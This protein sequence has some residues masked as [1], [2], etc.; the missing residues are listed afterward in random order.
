MKTTTQLTKRLQRATLGL[1][2]CCR[3][4]HAFA[5]VLLFGAKIVF[6]DSSLDRLIHLDIPANNRLE[7]SLIE[8]GTQAGMAVMMNTDTVAHHLVHEVH[9]TLSA[10][11]ALLL[12]LRDT[13]LTFTQEGDRIRVIPREP[14]VRSGLR[15]GG[16][17]GTHAAPLTGSS[18]N[19]DDESGE[20]SRRGVE[21]QEVVVTAE[22]REEPLNKVPISITALSQSSMDD[23]HIQKLG[24]L[25]NIVP[26]LYVSSP[27]AFGQ[28]G[29]TVAIRGVLTNNNAPTTQFYIDETPIAIRLM[30]GAAPSG[31]PQPLIFDLDRVEVLRGPQGTLFGASAMGGAI[32]FITPQP[33]LREASG[34]AKADVGYTEHGEASYEMGAAY[35]SP[36]VSG[37]AGFRVSAWYQSIGGFI[38]QED[39]FTGQIVKRNINSPGAYVVRPAFTWAPADGLTIT[40][41]LFLQHKDSQNPDAYWANGLPTVESN[42]HVWGGTGQ[43]MT[44]DLSVTALAIKYDFG[45]VSLQSDTSFLHRKLRAFDDFT[46]IAAYVYGFTDYLNPGLQGFSSTE[47]D[48]SSTNA[49]QQEFRLSSK[50]SSARINWVVGAFYR[51]AT[52]GLSQLIPPDLSPITQLTSGLTYQQYNNLY[53][54]GARDFVY[55]GQVLNAY[56]NFHTTDISEALFGDIGLNLTQRLKVDLGVRVEHT[57]VEHQDQIVAGPFDGL[58]FG[59]AI[60][61]D[62]SATPVTPRLSVTYQYTDN[63]MMYASAA[64]GF[65]P[66][67]GNPLT[68]IGDSLCDVSLHA[69]GLGGVPSGFSPDSLWSYEIGSK[70]FLFDKRLSIDSSVYLIKWTDIQTLVQLPSCGTDFTANRGEALSKGFDLQL[71]ALITEGLKLGVNVGYTNAYYPHT[72]YGAPD[73]TTGIAPLLNAGG[74]KIVPIVPWTVSGTGEYSVDTSSLWKDSRTYLRADFRWQS[75]TTARNPAVAGYDPEGEIYPDESFGVLNLRLGLAQGGWD[76]SA[77]VN[78]AA[79]SAPRV[80]YLHVYTGDPL[81]RGAAI[82]P[83]TVGLTAWRHF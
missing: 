66:G 77:Y 65:R 83:R 63:N 2:R 69:L 78:N 61:P 74:D 73:L 20:A 25:A 64:K 62:Q 50:D 16:E 10:R 40:P 30:N 15:D 52:E 22:R 31:G 82:Q 51:H 71:A 5:L 45:G 44:D 1:Y 46:Q 33:D 59:S 18:L 81:F 11:Q 56:Q 68:A 23:L 58:T 12:L 57:V 24:D 60:L 32:R 8:W 4:T 21:L 19:A 3:T 80:G 67:G 54:G 26:G 75:K 6:A 70:N 17:F 42:K 79:N 48:F 43:P 37:V 39:P 28:D 14:L 53:T 36:V 49:W 34:F 41:S 47:E 27:V 13:G 76:L 35:G 9:G 72:T 29:T 7:D 55:Q 38:D